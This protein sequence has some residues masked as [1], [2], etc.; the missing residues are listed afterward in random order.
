MK[1]ALTPMERALLEEALALPEEHDAQ[2][3]PAYR[4]YPSLVALQQAE[5]KSRVVDEMWRVLYDDGRSCPM[6]SIHHAA[7]TLLKEDADQG[8]TA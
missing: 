8:D 3:C 6:Y 1:Q 4:L 7:K 5:G 2:G